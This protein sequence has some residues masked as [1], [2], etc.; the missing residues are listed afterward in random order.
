MAGSSFQV[1]RSTTGSSRQ[2]KQRVHQSLAAPDWE[3]RWQEFAALDPQKLVGPLFSALCFL[4]QTVKWHAVTWFGLCV[5]Q[6]SQQRTE[7]ARIVMRRFLW[8]LNDE[9]G[10]IGWGAPEAMGEI[11]ACESTLAAEYHS[12]LLSYIQDRQGPDNYLEHLPLREGAYWGIARLAQSRPDLVQPSSDLLISA[13]D[14]EDSLTCR[15]LA[16]LSLAQLPASLLK[17]RPGSDAD[18]E[19]TIY[20]NRRFQ[21]LNLN[22]LVQGAFNSAPQ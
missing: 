7:A 10:G 13:A 11:M 9:S 6:I 16:S 3:S 14:N 2:L 20:W 1:M 17:I 4:N 19:L 12:L 5:P 15:V 21:T 18:Q 8:S 22:Q